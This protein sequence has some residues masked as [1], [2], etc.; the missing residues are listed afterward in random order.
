MNKLDLINSINTSFP[1]YVDYVIYG[2][3]SVIRIKRI[4]TKTYK[5]SQ[6]KEADEA[7]Y[8]LVEEALSHHEF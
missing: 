6:S 4:G 7:F 1:D 5:V 3:G 8:R 2:N